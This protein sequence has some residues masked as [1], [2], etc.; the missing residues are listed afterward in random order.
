MRR[1]YL[2]FVRNLGIVYH[3]PNLKAAVAHY[4]VMRLGR[5]SDEAITIYKDGEPLRVWEI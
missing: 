5:L 2:V 3:G 4:E 1:H